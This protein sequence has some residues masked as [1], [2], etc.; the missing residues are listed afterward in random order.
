M[1]VGISGHIAIA[2][3][4]LDRL[5]VTETVLR[6][7]HD[8]CGHG[9]HLGSRGP[10]EIE[11]FVD[12]VV[13]TERVGALAE[14]RGDPALRDRTAARHDLPIQVAGRDQAFQ[15]GELLFTIFDLSGEVIEHRGHVGGRHQ[16]TFCE[17]LRPTDGRRAVEVELA[18]VQVGHFSEASA[19]RIEADHM[20]IHLAY[21]GGERIQV[22]L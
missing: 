22:I 3:I 6:V 15:N 19:E 13:T 14:I 11:P 18:L 12:G 1:V 17:R 5:A 7:R 4:D 21:A 2:M 8:A 10:G 16:G 9:D 20:R